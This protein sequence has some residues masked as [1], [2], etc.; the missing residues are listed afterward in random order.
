MLATPI[1]VTAA[2]ADVM[3][4]AVAVDGKKRVWVIWSENRKSNYDIYA[5]S[6]AGGKWS[7]LTAA[8]GGAPNGAVQS[9]SSGLSWLI[10]RH[11]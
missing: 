6:Y 4:T 7:G 5:K 10:V 1:A 2:H 3:R 9:A 11:S 8:S